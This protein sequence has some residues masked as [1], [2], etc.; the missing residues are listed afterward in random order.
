MQ[1]AI[2]Y[3]SRTG[4]TK[5]MAEQMADLA[6]SAG[7]EWHPFI[8]A[9]GRT[10]RGGHRRADLHREL[11]GRALLHPATRHRRSASRRLSNRSWNIRCPS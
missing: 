2:V 11:D 8:G 1:L 7:H 3:D 10:R 9:S 6:R 4:T 5:A